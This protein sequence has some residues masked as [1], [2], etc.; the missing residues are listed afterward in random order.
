MKILSIKYVLSI[1]FIIL[2]AILCLSFIETKETE[3][4]EVPKR[5]ILAYD[6]DLGGIIVG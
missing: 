3:I 6:L 1:S 5:A 2:I 4:E